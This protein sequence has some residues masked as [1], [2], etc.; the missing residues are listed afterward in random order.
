MKLVYRPTLWFDVFAIFSTFFF[1]L[2]D[3][4]TFC[5]GAKLIYLCFETICMRVL[6][7]PFFLI[8]FEMLFNYHHNLLNKHSLLRKHRTVRAMFVRPHQ[9]AIVLLIKIANTCVLYSQSIVMY[10]SSC[11]HFSVSLPLPIMLLFA[12]QPFVRRRRRR[13]R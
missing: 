9:R 10:L 6:V 3:G 5:A 13:R 12:T 2:N 8:P 11:V 7:H 1:K 4:N